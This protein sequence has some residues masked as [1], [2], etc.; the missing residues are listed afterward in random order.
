[1]RSSKIRAKTA[2]QPLSA[3]FWRQQI[4]S[5]LCP[6]SYFFPS[7][8]QLQSLAT[9]EVGMQFPTQFLQKT[10]QS[11]QG[12]NLLNRKIAALRREIGGERV[13]ELKGKFV[14]SIARGISIQGQWKENLLE[15]SELLRGRRR[16]SG[17]G[18]P[19]ELIP[20]QT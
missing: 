4:Q 17:G 12:L 3:L 20:A 9:P 16:K 11:L 1:M 8:I 7:S 14:V 5:E 6:P 19:E 10:I 18:R 2:N 15:I 13:F